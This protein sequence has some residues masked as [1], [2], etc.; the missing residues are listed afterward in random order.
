[1]LTRRK[2][3]LRARKKRLSARKKHLKAWSLGEENCPR[4]GVP[5]GGRFPT[6]RRFPSIR[7]PPLETFSIFGRR[8]L[9]DFHD[10]E[11]HLHDLEDQLWIT[12]SYAFFEPL[13]SF[14]RPKLPKEIKLFI[15]CQEQEEH[16]HP[17]QDAAGCTRAF[18]RD[19]FSTPYAVL[20][21]TPN[22][23]GYKKPP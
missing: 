17:P 16:P 20:A 3:L 9:F 13:E 11:D 7:S 10:L 15:P 1:M 23:R 2:K 8:F 22:P 4:E 18:S 12:S 6:F 21:S 19:G 5:L 14:Q